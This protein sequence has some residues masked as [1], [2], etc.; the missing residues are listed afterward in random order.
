MFY[1]S[2]LECSSLEAVASLQKSLEMG[3]DAQVA[4]NIF[5][6]DDEAVVGEGLREEERCFRDR[7]G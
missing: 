5:Q 1:R 7:V 6:R 3:T 2:N 4:G